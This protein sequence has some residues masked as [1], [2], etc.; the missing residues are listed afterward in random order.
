M[1]WKMNVGG[2]VVAAPATF[3]V[4]GKQYVSIAAGNTLFVFGLR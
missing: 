2:T 4:G 3:L 1:L